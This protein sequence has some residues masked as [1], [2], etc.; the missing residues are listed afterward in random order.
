MDVAERA[1]PVVVVRGVRIVARLTGAQVVAAAAHEG[2]LR[3][4]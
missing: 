3:H 1:D 4:D 2:V